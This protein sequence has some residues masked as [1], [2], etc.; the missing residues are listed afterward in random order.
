MYYCMELDETISSLSLFPLI[1][2]LKNYQQR[3]CLVNKTELQ[4][5]LDH[6]RK[7]MEPW[8]ILFV[9]V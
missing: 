1:I 3:I 8:Y 7:N 6:I 9:W 2:F 4:K 5:V